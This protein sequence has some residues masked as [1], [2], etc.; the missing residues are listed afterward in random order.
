[1]VNLAVVLAAWMCAFG[2]PKALA[3]ERAEEKQV[4]GRNA[5]N[6]LPWSWRSR[7][8]GSA[9]LDPNAQRE[10]LSSAN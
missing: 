6:R 2:L 3:A 5:G 10:R 9:D 8:C 1:V 7:H 4:M